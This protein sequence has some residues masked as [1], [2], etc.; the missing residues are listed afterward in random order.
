[1]PSKLLTENR[2]LGKKGPK[3]SGRHSAEIRKVS[4]PLPLSLSKD[5]ARSIPQKEL[6]T[7]PKKTS[8]N[9]VLSIIGSLSL[10][11]VVLF[12]N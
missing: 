5:G 6:G 8:S 11:P 10:S 1:M 12:D 7:L 2:G 4:D 3:L 9:A